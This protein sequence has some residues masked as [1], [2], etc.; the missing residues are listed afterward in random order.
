MQID[1]RTRLASRMKLGRSMLTSEMIV[2][3]GLEA[4]GQGVD[5]ED[6][7]AWQVQVGVT[8]V[9]AGGRALPR[10]RNGRMTT[11]DDLVVSTIE[12]QEL[13]PLRTP[14][15]K[16]APL[17]RAVAFLAVAVVVRA[18]RQ[19]PRGLLTF[20][21]AIWLVLVPT[22]RMTERAKQ[23]WR[24]AREMGIDLPSICAATNA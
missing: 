17:A 4:I 19:L 11:P 15:R 23:A 18:A 13:E 3:V 8:R 16:S 9:G 22:W 1:V 24:A 14:A 2:A 12:S 7:F 21:R 20:V 10:C 5:A 6:R